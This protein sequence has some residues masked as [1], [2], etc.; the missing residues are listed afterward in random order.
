MQPTARVQ[1]TTP[2]YCTA[3]L[4]VLLFSGRR[5]FSAMHA[6][7]NSPL[8]LNCCLSCRPTLNRPRPQYKWALWQV[9]DSGQSVVIAAVGD[10]QSGWADFLAAL[11][12]ADCRYGGAQNCCMCVCLCGCV[13]LM[14]VCL[15]PALHT[16]TSAAGAAA[17][18]VL[19]LFDQQVVHAVRPFHQPAVF[20]FDF[21]T[22][23]GQKLH[24]MIFLNWCAPGHSPQ[25][26]C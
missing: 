22:S 8:T 15:L 1:S 23:D 18:S 9:D 6:F 21:T 5:A 13:R 3:V 20:D 4:R 14:C 24:K 7:F 19:L 11:P 25:R 2:F 12:D 26:S 16:R 10:K 17:T